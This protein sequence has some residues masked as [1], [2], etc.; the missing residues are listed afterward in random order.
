MKEPLILGVDDCVGALDRFDAIIDARSE[1]EFAEDHLPG[2]IN[3]P[4]LDDAQRAIIGT[5]YKQASAF[6]AKRLGAAWVS[7]NIAAVLEHRLAGMPREWQPLVYCWRGGNRSGSL[8]TVLARIGWRTTV[9]EG[10]YREFRRKVI[11]DL[12]ALSGGLRFVVLAG[13]TGSG[14]SLLLE[15]LG[16]AGAQVLDLELIAEHRGSVLGLLPGTRQPS[17]KQFETRLWSTIRKLDPSRCVYVESESRK[18]GQCQLPEALINAIRGSECVVIEATDDVRVELLMREY[19]HFT[20]SPAALAERLARLVP[21][22]GRECVDQ[23]NRM[24]AAGEWQALVTS[25][26][27]AH[28]DPAYDRSMARNFARLEQASRI[29][30]GSCAPDGVQAAAASILALA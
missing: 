29:A 26:L 14:K 28:Y 22:H 12:Q 6:E 4:V 15:R 23:W 9:L 11:A 21:L 24:A 17:Q 3:L 2:A 30:L 18:V 16:A 27:H 19:A 25:L 7:R 1:S 10:G 13:R 5:M 8:A 20:A